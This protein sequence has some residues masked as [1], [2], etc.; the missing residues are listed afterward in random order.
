MGSAVYLIYGDDEFLVTSRAREIIDGLIP[1]EDRTLGLETI[2][3]RA[4]TVAV[5]AEA[6]EKCLE[7]VNTLG[8]FTARKVVWL[9]DATC[10]AENVI[11]KSE[12]VKT[13]ADR[14][15]S[16]IKNGLPP[17][18][19][20]VISSPAVSKRYAFYKACKAAG[21]I[22]EF[23]V[24][25]K[26]YVAEKQAASYLGEVLRKAGIKMAPDVSALFLEKAGT[27][28]RQTV[29]EVEKLSLYLGERKQATLDDVRAITC[30]SRGALAWDLADAVGQRETERALTVLR[31]LL[32]QRES[33][34]GL[35]MALGSRIRDLLLYREAQDRG[36]LKVR[37][38]GY[39]DV[40]D[41]NGLPADM[42]EVMSEGLNRDPRKVHPFRAG[43]L[44]RQA[45][46]YTMREL[47]R[48]QRAILRAHEQ[49]V[50]SSKPDSIVLELLLVRMLAKP[51]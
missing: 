31:Q 24:S 12:T 19:V 39:R 40:V 46:K 36:W 29:N 47:R 43:L 3:G 22:E 45:R 38:E 4:E 11:G 26:A 30:S 37:K 14:L 49:I 28:S 44:A 8:F 50:S 5:A 20:L 23:S 41:W 48:C 34:V 10:F 13:R 15:G 32:F 9:R 16:T 1:E 25:E 7:A 35:I 2:D 27:D 51:R 18:V 17:E 6:L 21:E 33:S 42:E